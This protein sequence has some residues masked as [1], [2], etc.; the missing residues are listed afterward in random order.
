MPALLQPG[1]L[2]GAWCGE[3]VRM[4]PLLT[5]CTTFVCTATTRSKYTQWTQCL[6]VQ[7]PHA[8][9]THSGHSVC[10]YSNH[11][12]QIHTVDTVSVCTATTRSKYTVDAVSVCTA[13]TRS[14]YT[15]WTQCLCVQQP[16]AANT[17]SGHSACVYSNHTQQ[18]H[19]ADTVSAC[20]ATT[21]SIASVC[22]ATI[23][24]LSH[25]KGRCA[26]N[27]PMVFKA[28]KKIQLC[29]CVFWAC[30]WQTSSKS[31]TVYSAGL[32]VTHCCTKSSFHNAPPLHYQ[33]SKAKQ[34]P[35][36][37]AHLCVITN[38]TRHRHYQLHK[39]TKSRHWPTEWVSVFNVHQCQF[40][41]CVCVRFQCVSVPKVCQYHFSMCVSGSFCVS[42]QCASVSVFNVCQW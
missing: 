31:W 41:M 40:S 5:S 15:Q 7:Q 33:M 36:T 38:S 37:A 39:T 42:S 13:T 12:Q 14:K 23:Q 21:D 19:T 32:N 29:L 25:L 8:A 27:L 6:C 11:T 22:T 26:N 10:V 16:H 1:G 30:N 28:P 35:E 3:L 34:S 24:S 2:S 20:I 18:I 9:N 4:Q 17:H